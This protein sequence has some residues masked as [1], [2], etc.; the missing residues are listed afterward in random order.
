MIS[1]VHHNSVILSLPYASFR[2]EYIYLK[3]RRTM[4]LHVHR[5]KLRT[6]Y[7][8]YIPTYATACRFNLLVRDPLVSESPCFHIQVCPCQPML[9]RESL[10]QGFTI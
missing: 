7:V 8:D 2:H 4:V 10:L 6:F 3:D 1:R 5:A 9:R